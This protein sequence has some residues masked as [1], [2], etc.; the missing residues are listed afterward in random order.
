ML[1]RSLLVPPIDESGISHYISYRVSFHLELHCSVG[2]LKL[3]VDWHDGERLYGAAREGYPNFSPFTLQAELFSQ[4]LI[5][6]SL[7][8]PL[9]EQ[10]VDFHG[11]AVSSHNNGYS[12]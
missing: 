6:V 2:A 7:R 3:K 10:S 1:P 4:Y 11:L 8:A 9:V 12:M 5:D